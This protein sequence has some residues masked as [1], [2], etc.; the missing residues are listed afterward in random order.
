MKSVV[1]FIITITILLNLSFHIDKSPCQTIIFKK[2]KF[3]VCE[4]NPKKSKIDFYT[5]DEKRNK[6]KNFKRLQAY[7]KRQKKKMTF[8]I[9]GGIYD[10]G[11]IP[12]GLYIENGKQQSEIDKRKGR[13]LFY[14]KPNGVFVLYKDGT[15]AI[16]EL[17]GYI[18]K[19]KKGNI[20]YAL[21]S[22]P[23]LCVEGKI[24]PKFGAKSKSKYLR[25]GVGL[26]KSGNLV[27]AITQK[28]TNLHTFAKLYQEKLNCK[29]AL[30]LDGAICKMYAPSLKRTKLNGNLAAMVAV[31][32]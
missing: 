28:S 10:V 3:D 31:T 25:S 8:A 1:L 11:N 20:K 19:G 15:S 21:Q 7:L 18:E 27:F 29:N 26:N 4:F 2:Q 17:A 16:M 14:M 22:G 12:M 5:K 23:M 30:Y 6:L 32:K 13:G 24:H 9:N